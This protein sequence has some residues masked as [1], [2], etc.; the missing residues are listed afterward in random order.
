[1][2]A[3]QLAAARA[4]HA[5]GWVITFMCLRFTY[6]PVEKL[7]APSD[8]QLPAQ[9]KG[10]EFHEQ[11][12]TSAYKKPLKP[13]HFPRRHVPSRGTKGSRSAADIHEPLRATRH[14][15]EKNAT[16]MPH[17]R[18]VGMLPP[19]DELFWI[20]PNILKSDRAVRLP[21]ADRPERHATP[22][23]FLLILF[24]LLFFNSV[25]GAA[26]G[27]AKSPSATIERPRTI[28]HQDAKMRKRRQS[29]ESEHR[30]KNAEFLAK[31]SAASTFT[32]RKRGLQ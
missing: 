28:E 31:R 14:A 7:W 5:V 20:F 26:G 24:P 11:R 1:M 23:S 15:V 9:K 30:G 21:D 25:I 13:L 12:Q 29:K 8:W 18:K 17:D 10:N 22:T 6:G 2:P 16:A 3:S 4:M 32:R 27:A 19:Q